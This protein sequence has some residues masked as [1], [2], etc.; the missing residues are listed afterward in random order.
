MT[1]NKVKSREQAEEMA[2]EWYVKGVVGYKLVH[3][4]LLAEGYEVSI[5]TVRRWCN[6]AYRERQ[7]QRVSDW[8][9]RNKQC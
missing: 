1:T 7:N 5:H 2:R 4:M 6:A 3:K 8:V 9:R